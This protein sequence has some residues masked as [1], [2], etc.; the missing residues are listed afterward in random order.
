M[1]T[2]CNCNNESLEKTVTCYNCQYTWSE[3]MNYNERMAACPEHRA[4]YQ[5]RRILNTPSL[6]QT[7]ANTGYSVRSDG[8]SCYPSYTVNKN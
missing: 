2:L 7:C 4:R 5:D 8:T 6:C 3:K 1:S